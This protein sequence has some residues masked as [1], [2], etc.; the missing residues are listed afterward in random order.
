MSRAL[1]TVFRLA[2]PFAAAPA[3]MAVQAASDVIIH[4]SDRTFTP[5]KLSVSRGSILRFVN[6]ENIV[7]HAYVD[8]PTFKID[9]GDIAPGGAPALLFDKEGRFLVRCAIHPRM[10]LEVDVTP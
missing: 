2:A 1:R 3:M 6:D 4:Q 7:H 5:A 9:S 10:K 8:S